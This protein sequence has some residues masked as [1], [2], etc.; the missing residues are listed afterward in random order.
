MTALQSGVIASDVSLPLFLLGLFPMLLLR[1]E[2]TYL[3]LSFILQVKYKEDYHKTKDKYTTVTETVDSER[4]QNLKNLF[5]NVSVSTLFFFPLKVGFLLYFVCSLFEDKHPNT[6]LIRA[7]D[8]PLHCLSM[9]KVLYFRQRAYFLTVV[10]VL[11]KY[12]H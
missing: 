3:N 7:S 1:T 2:T 9:G 8:S 10:P 6:E 4:V 5:S 11:S 12:M